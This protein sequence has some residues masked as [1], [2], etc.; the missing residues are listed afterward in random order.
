MRKNDER[1]PRPVRG[2]GEIGSQNKGLSWVWISGCNQ[3]KR[4]CIS[5]LDGLDVWKTE[6]DD[7]YDKGVRGTLTTETFGSKTPLRLRELVRRIITMGTLTKVAKR[8]YYIISRSI[9]DVISDKAFITDRKTDSTTDSSAQDFNLY[10]GRN[11]FVESLSQTEENE[12]ELK[13]RLQAEIEDI[14]SQVGE[15]GFTPDDKAIM[16][17]GFPIPDEYGSYEVVPDHLRKS[18]PIRYVPE[19]DIF[20]VDEERLENREAGDF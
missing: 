4:L 20:I 5:V 8:W 15:D 17:S 18:T 16:R 7:A 12:E 11:N 1:N 6:D 9:S 3:L 2:S 14:M 19:E 10:Q 13:R